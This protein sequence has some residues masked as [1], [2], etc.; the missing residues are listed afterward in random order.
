MSAQSKVLITGASSGIGSVYADRFA[1]RGHNLILVARDTNRLDK[2]SKDLQEKYGV[3]V[4][5]IQADLSNDQDI[6]KIEDVLK[7]DA[8]IEILVNNAGIALNGTFLTQDIKD[9][10]KL[11]TLNMTAVVRLSHAI[12]QSLI[13]KGK[14]AIINLGS[15]LGLAP[16]LGST[17]YGASKSFIQFFSQGLYLELKDHGVHVQAVLPSATKTEIW[18]R[19]GIDLSQVP[20]LMNVND[21]VDAALIG[22]DRKETIT[23]P[24]LKDENQWNNF[25]KSR[26]TLLPN[27]SSADVAQRYKN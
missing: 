24:V 23:I 14:G 18:E 16:E 13:H 1:Q 19:S 4:E 25:E 22:F 8:D 21:L 5:F 2:I 7:N 3:Q 12:S 6:S 15:V 26:I 17:I 10:E 27:F 9:I 11:I 20:P